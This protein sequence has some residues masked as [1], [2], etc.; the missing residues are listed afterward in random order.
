MPIIIEGGSRSAGGWWARHLRNT[1][2]NERAQLVQVEGLS[3]DTVPD[4]FREMR[5][6]AQ[7]TRCGNYFYQASINPRADENL[8]PA[9]W[10]DAA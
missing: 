6:L 8:T 10:R 7:G 2:T 3:T 9:Q 4:M 1:A 5:A